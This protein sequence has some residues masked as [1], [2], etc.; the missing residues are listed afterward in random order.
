MSNGNG[1]RAPAVADA[2]VPCWRCGAARECEHRRD[3]VTVERQAYAAPSERAISG[4]GRYRLPRGVAW[5][6][7]D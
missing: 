6:F 2:S 4:G 7:K 3:L 1:L 5:P